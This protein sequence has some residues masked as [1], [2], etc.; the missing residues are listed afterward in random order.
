MGARPER[1]G[2]GSARPS[3][4]DQGVADPE[5]SLDPDSGSADGLGDST[6]A[7]VGDGEGDGEAETRGTGTPSD[8]NGAADAPGI[9]TV[10]I[11]SAA[12]ADPP[13]APAAVASASRPSSAATDAVVNARFASHVFRDQWRSEVRSGRTA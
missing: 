9:V 6:R 1:L 5:G 2:E 3:G 11:G 8:G 10:G 12:A 13:N 4:P 7:G